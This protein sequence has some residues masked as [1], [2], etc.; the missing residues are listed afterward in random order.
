MQRIPE[1]E[2]M[3]EPRQAH[4]YA[5]ADFSDATRLFIDLF[6][7]N[8]PRHRPRRVVDLGCGPGQITMAFAAAHPGSQITGIDGSNTMLEIATERLRQQSTLTRRVEWWLTRL[9][10]STTR[11]YDTLI[12]NSLLHHLHEPQIL[13]RQIQNWGAS[14]AA[15]L[16]MDLYRPSSKAEAVRIVERYAADAPEILRRDFFNSLCAAFTREEIHQQLEISGLADFQVK[17]VSD[18][19][20]AVWGILK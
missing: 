4:S 9:P 16:V 12:S 7:N 18:R 6:A 8:F 17:V 11:S 3:E 10:D 1:P 19:H 20:L 15:V 13:W 5:E 2:L 14:G